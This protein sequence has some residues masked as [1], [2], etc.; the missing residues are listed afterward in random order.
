MPSDP[1][2]LIPQQLLAAGITPSGEEVQAMIAAAPGRQEMLDRLYAIP[3]AR[4]EEP[5]LVF[6]AT[7]PS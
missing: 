7:F 1:T 3:E 5:C 4:Y 2:V 6:D